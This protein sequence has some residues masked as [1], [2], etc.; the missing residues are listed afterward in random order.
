MRRLWTAIGFVSVLF[1]HGSARAYQ[2]S[3]GAELPQG[4]AVVRIPFKLHQG[5]AV[6]VR[7]SIG[8]V[9]NL[10][11]LIDTGASPSV[12]DRRLAHKLRLG[13]SSAQLSTFTQR[14]AVDQAIATDVRLGPFRAGELRVLVHDL[15][16]LEA[17][18]GVQ[19]D[20]MIG[21]DFLE[22]GPFTI[23]YVSRTLLF[24]PV[25]PQ[26]ETIPYL[27]DLPYVVVLMRVQDAELPLLVDTGAHDLIVFEDG[28]EDIGTRSLGESNST[29]TNLGG[30]AKVKSLDLSH[31]FLGAMPWSDREA[32]VLQDSHATYS[33]GFKG[34]LG[35]A[36]LQTARVGFDPVRRV[37]A[38]ESNIPRFALAPGPR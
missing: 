35:V 10:N 3:S 5:F 34:L 7:G 23:D 8:T 2:G 6:V 32:F 25:D 26:L 22:Q 28:L 15:S 4:G 24:G 37:F 20:A 30:T 36:A 29:W 18:L 31:S 19:V 9:K 33:A 13:V 21:Y 16:A 1:L 27:S 17:R 11:F 12:L 38:W 14:V